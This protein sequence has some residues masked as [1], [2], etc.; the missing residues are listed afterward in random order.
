MTNN[1]QKKSILQIKTGVRAG[2]RTTGAVGGAT[3][4]R[5]AST[6]VASPLHAPVPP[7]DPLGGLVGGGCLIG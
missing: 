1:T 2:P 4:S 6:V 3:V 5:S 7:C